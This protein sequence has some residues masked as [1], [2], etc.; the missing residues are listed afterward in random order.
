MTK[1][2]QQLL[3]AFNALPNQSQKEV[4]ASLLRLPIEV[5]YTPPTDE[6]LRCA[7]DAVFVE[8]DRSEA[9]A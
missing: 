8:F 7:A 6:D 3:S 2:A 1:A 5:P 4:L 9:Q